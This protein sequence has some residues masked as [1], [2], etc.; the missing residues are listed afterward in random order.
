MSEQ[1]ATY[2]SISND[3]DRGTKD[4]QKEVSPSEVF[5]LYKEVPQFSSTVGHGLYQQLEDYESY[6]VRKLCLIHLACFIGS[7]VII[8]SFVE[9]WTVIDSIYFS[10]VVFTTVGRYH[11][12]HIYQNRK[13]KS[14]VL[15]ETNI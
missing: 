12:P 15:W 6:Q 5:Q 8:F 4:E 10:V 14:H 13:Y 7:A 3:S 9:G 1:K 11:V 2:G